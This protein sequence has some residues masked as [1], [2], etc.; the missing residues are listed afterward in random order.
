VRM[1]SDDA[2]TLAAIW[3][4][5]PIPC[6]AC[7]LLVSWPPSRNPVEE[8]RVLPITILHFCF[9]TIVLSTHTLFFSKLLST[10]A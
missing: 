4:G 10:F 9:E 8:T 1:R 7:F 5:R 3:L 2:V 6:G